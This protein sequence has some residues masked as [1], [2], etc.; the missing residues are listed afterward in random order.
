M[1][2]NRKVGIVAAA[3]AL[4]TLAG[5]QSSFATSR[6]QAAAPIASVGTASTATRA[7]VVPPLAKPPVVMP[8]VQGPPA[9]R[10]QTC[11][12]DA[13]PVH[14]RKPESAMRY[15]AA[16]WNCGDLR[17]MRRVTNPDSRTQL[18]WMTA[19]ATN[20]QLVGCVDYGVPGRHIYTCSFTH[21]YPKGVA[22]EIPTATGKGQAFLSVS[23]ARRPGWYVSVSQGCG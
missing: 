11:V 13:G 16:A 18:Q 1:N 3:A 5:N 23:P 19:E 14:F 17:A 2:T 10:K 15:L 7:A 8:V 6:V 12:I 22:H 9:W 20:L 4:A 21:D